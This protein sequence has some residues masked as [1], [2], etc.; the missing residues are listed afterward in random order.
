MAFRAGLRIRGSEIEKVPL[1][2]GGHFPR[3][4]ADPWG[5]RPVCRLRDGV[6]PQLSEMALALR[7]SL[8]CDIADLRNYHPDRWGRS[9]LP[10]AVCTDI[11]DLRH[12][13]R[14]HVPLRWEYN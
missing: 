9:P 14:R 11:V 1:K 13:N 8:R 10:L 12:R 7:D 2:I 6:A 4:E 5:S 3:D